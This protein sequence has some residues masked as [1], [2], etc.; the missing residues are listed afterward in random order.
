MI[1]FCCKGVF[2]HLDQW[3]DLC[4]PDPGCPC[5]ESEMQQQIQNCCNGMITGSEGSNW[6]YPLFGQP[7]SY[8]YTNGSY[9]IGPG[10][11][12]GGYK[13]DKTTNTITFSPCLQPDR[14]RMVYIGDFMNDMG[15]ALVP[16]T[17]ADCQVLQS[18]ADYQRK[19]YSPNPT[20]QRQWK[21]AY[22]IFYQNVRDWN[23]DNSILDYTTWIRL[24]RT[25]TFLGVHAY[26]MAVRMLKY[27][28]QLLMAALS[29]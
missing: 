29:K 7:Y 23:T 11:S 25:Q 15:N 20:L 24:I 17:V 12:N 13:I 8:S 18:Y 2:I 3:E 22:Q 14:I 5:N 9:A 26:F 28:G 27:K 1:G 16:Q 10:F 4:T 21:D 19:L 6:I